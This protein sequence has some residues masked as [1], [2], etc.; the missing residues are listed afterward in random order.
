MKVYMRH[1]VRQLNTFSGFSVG[2]CIN[3]EG[4]LLPTIARKITWQVIFRAIVGNLTL[5]V[6]DQVVF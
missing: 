6:K 2:F 3:E 4:Y 1:N 5:A